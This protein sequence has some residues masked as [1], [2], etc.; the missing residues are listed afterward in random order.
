M[1]TCQEE[2]S[3]EGLV[4]ALQLHICH[5]GSSH[6]GGW[7]DKAV[8]HLILWP[9]L[10]QQL[11]NT[12]EASQNYADQGRAV[13]CHQTSVC[14]SLFG[15]YSDQKRCYQSITSHHWKMLSSFATVKCVSCNYTS[16]CTHYKLSEPVQQRL[17]MMESGDCSYKMIQVISVIH[18][19]K[20]WSMSSWEEQGWGE[21]EWKCYWYIV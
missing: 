21:L 11:H 18:V 13:L 20:H 14:I 17:Q 7:T 19:I 10:S 2:N 12:T 5:C 8:H 15:G 6:L 1:D 4:H 9:R 16:D 3:S